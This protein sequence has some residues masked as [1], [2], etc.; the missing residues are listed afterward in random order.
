MFDQ[1]P[2]MIDDELLLTKIQKIFRILSSYQKEYQQYL[3]T[4]IFKQVNHT[5]DIHLSFDLDWNDL[6]L[7]KQELQSLP[8]IKEVKE[9]KL[10]RIEWQE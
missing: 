1:P 4:L 8:Y 7:L 10:L 5:I 9:D 3:G 2:V 6:S